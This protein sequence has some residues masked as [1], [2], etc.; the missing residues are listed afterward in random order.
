MAPLIETMLFILLVADVFWFVWFVNVRI[1]VLLRNADQ[2][3]RFIEGWRRGKQSWLLRMIGSV[4]YSPYVAPVK[5]IAAFVAITG[6][7]IALIK[8]V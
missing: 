4:M 6:L 3:S 8:V 5:A 7:L 2:E 1:D